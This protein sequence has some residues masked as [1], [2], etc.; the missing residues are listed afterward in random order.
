MCCCRTDLVVNH[1]ATCYH[2]TDLVL[3]HVTLVSPRRSDACGKFRSAETSYRNGRSPSADRSPTQIHI[4][5]LTRA[6]TGTESGSDGSQVMGG[7]K[8][9]VVVLLRL[10]KGQL[11]RAGNIGHDETRV[12]VSITATLFFGALRA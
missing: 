3:S 9:N 1:V 4:A 8:Q 10:S 7:C 6:D 5:P 12:F 2:R 11:R